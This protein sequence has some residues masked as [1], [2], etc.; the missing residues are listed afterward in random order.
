MQPTSAFW[1]ALKLSSLLGRGHVEGR[2]GSCLG[3]AW[4]A[5]A[6]AGE[7]VLPQDLA[8]IVNAF[9]VFPFLVLGLGGVEVEVGLS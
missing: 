3:R 5:V 9:L 1:N 4:R 8:L 6:F 2:L 7:D